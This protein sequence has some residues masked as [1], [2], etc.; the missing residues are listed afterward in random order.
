MPAAVHMSMTSPDTS[1]PLTQRRLGVEKAEISV[2][3]LTD[4]PR[5]VGIYHGMMGHRG[6]YERVSDTSSHSN[7]G[8]CKTRSNRS[9]FATIVKQREQPV[10]SSC[11]AANGIDQSQMMSIRSPACSLNQVSSSLISPSISSSLLLRLLCSACATS[12]ACWAA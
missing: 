2:L 11:I 9:Y 12:C 4:L 5:L 3:A 8:R 7:V 6:R 10:M 1:G